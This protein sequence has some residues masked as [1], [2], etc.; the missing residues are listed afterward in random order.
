VSVA[1]QSQGAHSCPAMTSAEVRLIH[2]KHAG[3][4]RA[5]RKPSGP[6]AYFA[7]TSRC[8]EVGRRPLDMT[9][10]EVSRQCGAG[11]FRSS[12]ATVAP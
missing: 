11:G 7:D 3:H 12:V 9:V 1:V 4:D 2:P 5:G 8:H 6:P 10:L